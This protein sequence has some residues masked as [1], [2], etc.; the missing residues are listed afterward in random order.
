MPRRS[1]T[2]WRN[3]A[4]GPHTSQHIRRRRAE[5]R[6]E[7]RCVVLVQWCPPGIRG[8]WL[9]S[10]TQNQRAW[11]ACTASRSSAR[12]PTR[13]STSWLSSPRRSVRRRS[14]SSAWS[15]RPASGRGPTR[16]RGVRDALSPPSPRPARRASP[17]RL[18]PPSRP[19]DALQGAN[20][21]TSRGCCRPLG[22]AVRAGSGSPSRVAQPP[23]PICARTAS[24]A[25]YSEPCATTTSRRPPEANSRRTSRWS[26]S[27]SS[28]RSGHSMA[29]TPE[30]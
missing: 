23:L 15:T 2:G 21:R 9:F 25:S 6:I 27:G 13:C 17:I 26:P 16:H 12:R 5:G 14:A 11:Q 3:G 19:P 1:T 22:L 24:A 20:L 10:L 7:E 18:R 28:R 30:P 29:Q 8:R 4:D